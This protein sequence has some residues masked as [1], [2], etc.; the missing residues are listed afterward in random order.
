MCIHVCIANLT[1]NLKHKSRH[2]S[3]KIHLQV[4]KAQKS[5]SRR[6]ARSQWAEFQYLNWFNLFAVIIVNS[7]DS[8]K[9]MREGLLAQIHM[10]LSSWG[11]GRNRAGDLRIICISVRCRALIYWTK[12]TNSESLQIHQDPANNAQQSANCHEALY[13]RSQSDS[14]GLVKLGFL[15]KE[16]PF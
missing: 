4:L 11:F 10:D 15:W 5:V 14:Q 2:T 8:L 6:I 7:H 9:S 1:V 12:V 3:H 16:N 13:E